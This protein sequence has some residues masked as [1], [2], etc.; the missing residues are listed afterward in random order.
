MR[1]D[2]SGVFGSAFRL[3]AVD[4]AGNATYYQVTVSEPFEGPTAMLYGATTIHN[5][6]TWERFS[7]DANYD[8]EMVLETNDSLAAGAA[9]GDGY[10]FYSGTR[11][12][13]NEQKS[14]LFVVD[15]PSFENPVIIGEISESPYYS[16]PIS[17][18]TY[19]TADGNLYY[20]RQR[21]L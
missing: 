19:N 21:A 18:M 16:K 13:N 20:V 15:Y 3:A 5:G 1:L 10:L 14:F 4:Y 11:R 7:S 2:I 17:Y 8:Y 12:V 6:A 9:Y